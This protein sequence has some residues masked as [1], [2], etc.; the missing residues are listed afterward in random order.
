MQRFLSFLLILSLLAVP[1]YAESSGARSGKP[2]GDNLTW[3]VDGTTLYIS[4][5]GEMDDF[6][7]KAPW[8]SYQETLTQVILGDGVT[9]VGDYAFTDFDRLKFV[10][11]GT[12]LVHIGVE[13]FAGCDGL[14]SITLPASFKKFGAN[15]FRSCASLKEIY[16]S[17]YFPRFDS[18]AVWDTYLTI[19]YSKSNPWSSEYTSQLESAFPGLTFRAYEGAAPGSAPETEETTL[20]IAPTYATEPVTSPVVFTVPTQPATEATMPYVETVPTVPETVPVTVPETLPATVPTLAPPT[21]PDIQ[22]TAEE[23]L[24]IDETT[25]APTQPRR[26]TDGSS[27][28]GML[29]LAVTLSIIAISALIFRISNRPK[30]RKKKKS[31]R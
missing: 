14:R 31:R 24:W 10:D 27:V 9:S 6:D 21:L 29:I 5:T 7:G 11:F 18:G 22:P 8:S 3:F 1:C 15:S 12:T 17:G 26:G 28:Y 25:A 20:S 23:T 19:Y 2:C 30:K 13:A 4:G 16:C